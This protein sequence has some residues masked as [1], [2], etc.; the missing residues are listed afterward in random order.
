[1]KKSTT[2][3]KSL[4][5]FFRGSLKP[6]RRLFFWGGTLGAAL[7]TVIADILPSVVVAKAFDVLQYNSDKNLPL[8]LGDFS[9]YLW[10]YIGLV[11][12]AVILWRVQVWMV[13]KYEIQLS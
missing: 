10:I 6:G 3:T 7:A 11:A 12:S 9:S 1:M 13:W 5:L 8:Q 2:T 4:R